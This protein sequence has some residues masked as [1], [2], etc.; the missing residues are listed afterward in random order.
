MI[1]NSQEIAPPKYEFFKISDFKGGGGG[2]YA[3]C[4]MHFSLKTNWQNSKMFSGPAEVL[5][6]AKVCCSYRLDASLLTRE[7]RWI[8]PDQN[9]WL[10]FPK[11]PQRTKCRR[12]S[13]Q[14]KTH[15]YAILHDVCISAHLPS[16]ITVPFLLK[17]T[18]A[19]STC[20]LLNF[21][22][23]SLHFR[24][25]TTFSRAVGWIV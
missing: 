22:L 6:N 10:L 24:H 5:Q 20:T 1:L 18:H 14:G 16:H 8:I 11:L 3:L 21:H 23:K 13:N 17:L 9:T 2:D 7:Q 15:I 25:R 19:C 12:H 4:I